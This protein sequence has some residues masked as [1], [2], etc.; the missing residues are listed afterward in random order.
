MRWLRVAG[1]SAREAATALPRLR[2]KISN[3][4]SAVQDTYFSTKD[5]FERH[6]VVFT[7]GTSFASLATAWAGYSLRYVHQSKVEQRL[8]SIEQAMRGVHLIGES[9]IKKMVSPGNTS[10]TYLI[11]TAGTSLVIGY[12]LGWRGGKWYATRKFRKEQL[13]SMGMNKMQKWQFLKNPFLLPLR[14]VTETGGKNA[15]GALRKGSV[16]L[17]P[18]QAGQLSC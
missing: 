12:G 14:M 17:D 13:R 8:D 5:V 11:A 16:A 10:T 4:W 2:K 15:S 18:K 3:S 6:R 7:V 9:D 1:S